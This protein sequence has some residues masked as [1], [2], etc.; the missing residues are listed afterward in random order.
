MSLA[1]LQPYRSLQV[2]ETR[3][4][5]EKYEAGFVATDGLGIELTI[6]QALQL[7]AATL[8]INSMEWVKSGNR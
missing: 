8:S 6:T 7:L 1:N 2:Y 3:L 4:I 5:K